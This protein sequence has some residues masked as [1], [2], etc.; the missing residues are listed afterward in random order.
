[1]LT[2]YRFLKGIAL[3]KKCILCYYALM[4][5]LEMSVLN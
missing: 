2:G 4:T 3:R 5:G 1:M